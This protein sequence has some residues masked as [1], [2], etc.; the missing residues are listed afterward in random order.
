MPS[1]FF[2]HVFLP[3]YLFLIHLLCPYPLQKLKSKFTVILFLDYW[4]RIL[5]GLLVSAF[6]WL[7]SYTTPQPKWSF[8]SRKLSHGFSCIYMSYRALY[9]I[10]YPQ[11]TSP[12]S[13]H[14]TLCFAHCA[15]VILALFLTLNHA[16]LLPWGFCTRHSTQK[17]SRN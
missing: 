10:I 6:T 16:M 8:S 15:L 11:P 17:T 2:L 5:A 4:N 14:S 9:Y 13:Y 1:D 7:N 3:I 12:N